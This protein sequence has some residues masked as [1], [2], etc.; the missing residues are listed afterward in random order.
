MNL[1][2]LRYPGSKAQIAENIAISCN[3]EAM[4]EPFCGGASVGLYCL[5]NKIIKQ[6]YLNDADSGCSL[7]WRFLT[8]HTD[9][10]I[11][12]IVS[13]P[14]TMEEREKNKI[15]LECAKSDWK[16]IGFAFFFLNRVNYSGIITSGPIGGIKQS[17]KYKLDC[18][19]NKQTVINKIKKIRHLFPYIQ[20]TNDDAITAINNIP[21]NVFVFADPPYFQHGNSLY[22]TGMTKDDHK[23]FADFMIHD[24]HNALIT[25]DN[26]EYINSL[27][28]GCTTFTFDMK[29]SVTSKRKD[30]ELCIIFDRK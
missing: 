29:Y 22:R 8:S 17:G 26:D 24:H 3:K 27:Y 15:I 11:D 13:T 28:K 25:Y 12:R 4:I 1:S 9:E 16:D 6:L 2:P 21:D 23:R 30:T 20:I 10:F 5:Y 18:R 7:F 14:I 19:F